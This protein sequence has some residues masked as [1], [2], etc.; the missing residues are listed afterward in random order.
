MGK[1]LLRAV[2]YI[3]VSREDENPE[4]QRHAIKEYAARHGVEIVKWYE[5][6]GVSGGVPVFQRPGFRKLLRFADKER[7]RVLIIYDLTRF[8]RSFYDGLTAFHRL[9]QDGWSVITVAGVSPFSI[10][11]PDNAAGQTI[12]N[13][14]T[15]VLLAMGEWYRMDVAERTRAGIERAK[16]EGKRVGRP[17]LPEET[18]R[19][20]VELAKQGY[21]KTRIAKAVGVSRTTVWRVLKNGF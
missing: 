6:V 16:A 19:A 7:V 14:L 17:P 18:R 8:S 11:L 2:A 12:R 20:I 5:D 1:D 3:R 4:N 13:I 15:A 21:P 10:P 9:L